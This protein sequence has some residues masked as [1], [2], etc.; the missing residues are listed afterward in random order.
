VHIHWVYRQGDFSRFPKVSHGFVEIGKTVSFGP[1]N[2]K[3]LPTNLTLVNPPMLSFGNRLV[4][5]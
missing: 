1:F 3:K 4:R 5:A 2:R